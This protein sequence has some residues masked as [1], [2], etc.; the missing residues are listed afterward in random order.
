MTMR[1]H[2]NEIDTDPDMVA[3]LVSA[4]FPELASLPIER[5]PSAGTD[6]AL[7]RLGHEWVARLPRIDWALGQGEKERQWLPKLAPHLPLTLPVQVAQGQPGEG[8]PYAWTIYRWL[9]GESATYERLADPNQAARDLAAF[10]RALHRIDPS[11][12]PDARVQQMRGSPLAQ[13]DAGTRD[14]I[15]QL[16][17]SMD[18]QAAVRIWDAALQAPEWGEKPVWFHGDL[19]PGNLLVDHG[20]LSA[21]IDWSGLGVGDPACDLMSAWGLFRGESRATFRAALGLDDAT[22]ARA[23]GHALSQA[24]IFIPYYV[25]SNPVGVA[26][27]WRQLN[28][29][30]E[31]A[32]LL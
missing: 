30:L 15:A 7:Y 27:S 10:I 19:L 26:N 9:P 29:V 20:R 5:V 1:M 22:W 14:A 18:V 12:G 21:V 11:G 28:A 16:A 24:A 25:N 23:R 4:Q 31:E 13:R 32:P 8:Y 2:D 17:G 3:R 6:N